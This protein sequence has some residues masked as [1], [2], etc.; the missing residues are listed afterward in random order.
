M[1]HL[2]VLPSTPP[3]HLPLPVQLRHQ[4]VQQPAA[5]GRAAAGGAGPGCLQ[6]R[7]V[8]EGA[9]LARGRPAVVLAVALLA[10]LKASPTSGCWLCCMSGVYCAY[11]AHQIILLCLSLAAGVRRRWSRSARRTT[12]PRCCTP[13]TPPSEHSLSR[14]SAA[15]CWHWLEHGIC[16]PLPGVLGCLAAMPFKCC[17]LVCAH[18][19]SPQV[20]QGAAPEAAVLLR[21]GLAA[22]HH[23]PL[24]GVWWWCCWVAGYG[25]MQGV[26][27]QRMFVPADV[28]AYA[29]QGV[30]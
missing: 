4:D 17:L 14:F 19:H 5:V 27:R 20:R 16:N 23:R 1:C 13:T 9:A 25:R 10:V 29:R 12:S 8:R 22:G 6:R 2:L 7:P 3:P 21:V 26:K 15:P 30:P 28:C 24:P 11:T 18:P